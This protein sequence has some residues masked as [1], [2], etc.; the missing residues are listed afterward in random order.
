MKRSPER[1][2][3]QGSR[4]IVLA[5]VRDVRQRGR[6][7][8]QQQREGS[9]STQFSIGRAG[10]EPATFGLKVRPE[11]LSTDAIGGRLGDRDWSS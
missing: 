1:E 6:R 8:R 2:S 4:G 10:I 3:G 9:L 11:P 7:E 5:Q